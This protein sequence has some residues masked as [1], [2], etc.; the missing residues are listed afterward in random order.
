VE[1][2]RFAV[3]AMFPNYYDGTRVSYSLKAI[4]ETMAGSGVATSAYVLGKARGLQDAVTPLLPATLYRYS[5]RWVPRPVE[6][7]VAR[8]GR[9]MRPGDIVYCWLSNPPLLTRALQHRKLL[10]M[11]EMINCTLARRRAELA[12]A[13]HLLGR[14]DESGILDADIACERAELIAADGVFCPNEHVLESVR[15]Y[16][17]PA[18]N[19][20]LTSYGWSPA[21]ILGETRLVEKAPG[22][23]LLFAGTA[24]VR[25]GFPWLLKAWELADVAGRLLVAGHVDPAL[26]R[27]HAA[28]LRRPDVLCLG[29]VSDIGAAYRSADAF[30]FPSW[31]E[32]G[33]MVTIEA[34]G[35]GLPCIVT[36]MGSAGILSAGSGAG[37]VVPP[38][39]VAALSAA[40]RR[41]A[42]DEA[43]RRQ[44][45]RLARQIA[46]DYTWENVG[47]R[48]REDLV[49]L[50]T[51]A[52]PSRL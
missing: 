9:R 49:R 46:A 44:A 1:Q 22:F 4:V 23:N 43:L 52:L 6:A 32:G 29:H 21:R 35:A 36:P 13:S 33:P 15:A 45:S 8:F 7:M 27:E 26:Q 39:D 20:Y 18:E 10:V 24:D 42:G 31:E 28:H 2:E 41:L 16:G 30:C 11:R 17:V 37:L 34:M 14:G 40:I 5:S 3:H 25:K 51:R 50:R 12:R 38:G 19:C 48:R 47:R